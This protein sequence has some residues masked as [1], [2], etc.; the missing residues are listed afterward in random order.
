MGNISNNSISFAWRQ[1][2]V[3]TA[4]NYNNLKSENDL[5]KKGMR[6]TI[7]LVKLHPKIKNSKFRKRKRN[8]ISNGSFLL[9]LT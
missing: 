7:I 8:R 2:S 1:Q 3:R 9:D 5:I 4:H 6:N